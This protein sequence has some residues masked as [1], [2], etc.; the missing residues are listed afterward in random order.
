MYINTPET[1][2][3]LN[4]RTLPLS[5]AILQTSKQSNDF[6]VKYTVLV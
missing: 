6:N 5:F 1:C 4:T 3:I 2:I